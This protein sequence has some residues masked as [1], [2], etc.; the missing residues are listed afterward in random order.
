MSSIACDAIMHLCVVVC[1]ARYVDAAGAVGAGDW[2]TCRQLVAAVMNP[3]LCRAQKP[4]AKD[5]PEV[6]P[7]VPKLKG[8]GGGG[9]ICVCLVGNS[10]GF[11]YKVSSSD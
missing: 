6:L 2:Q 3:T 5:C 9:Q 8:R 1:A 7:K 4:A 10:S 11:A